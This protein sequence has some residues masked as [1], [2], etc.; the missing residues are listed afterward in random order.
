M[1]Y[2]IALMSVLAALWLGLSGIYT[3]LLLSFGAVSV[4][5]T[6]ILV[7]RLDILDREVVPYG[8]LPAAALYWVWLVGEII[9]ANWVVIKACL[10]AD[11]D[12]HPALVRV[13]TTCRSD[14][15]KATFANSITLTPGTVTLT[16]DG[17]KLLVHALYEAE[18]Q[19]EAFIEMDRRSA[20]AID[21][22]V[23]TE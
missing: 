9:K 20:R 2:F 21:G 10:R 11:L 1:T 18:A 17:D 22:R 13:K 5:I 3:P 4:V 7:Y 15:A 6:M 14:I 23:T 19:P 16:V 12:I 8:A